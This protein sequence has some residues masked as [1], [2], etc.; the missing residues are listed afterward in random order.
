MC[1]P[2]VLKGTFRDNFF[3]GT[4]RFVPLSHQEWQF[5]YRWTSDPLLYYLFVCIQYIIYNYTLCVLFRRLGC[6]SSGSVLLVSTF[7]SVLLLFSALVFSERNIIFLLPAFILSITKWDETKQVKWLFAVGF[8]AQIMLYMKEPFVFFLFTFSIARIIYSAF[9]TGQSGIY[10]FLKD[11]SLDLLLILLC[12]LWG[13]TY[14]LLVGMNAVATGTGYFNVTLNIS[15]IFKSLPVYVRHDTSTI[16]LFALSVA[17]PFLSPSRS[18]AVLIPLLLGSWAYFIVILS[19]GITSAWYLSV[20][21]VTIALAV[22]GMTNQIKYSAHAVWLKSTLIAICIFMNVTASL[23]VL[24]YRTDWILRNELISEQLRNKDIQSVC[25]IGD[26]WD[27]SML[28]D[29]LHL[30]SPE[31]RIVEKDKCGS[32]RSCYVIDLHTYKERAASVHKSGNTV[33]IYESNVMRKTLTATPGFMKK[34]LEL[35][36]RIW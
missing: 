4:G 28:V 29:K 25:I 1:I 5:V 15:N 3:T 22:L 9:K 18:K 26:E 31:I 19:I 21:S 24:A 6:L 34:V 14:L 23:S 17:I 30:E 13:M 36:Y 2:R 27:R 32:D 10:K 35:H 11:E 16:I 12:A 33:W 7:P 20:P 8:L